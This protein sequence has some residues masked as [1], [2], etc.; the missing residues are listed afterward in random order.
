MSADWRI[1]Y[2]YINIRTS[3]ICIYV[4]IYD[5]IFGLA[6]G[7]SELITADLFDV[8]YYGSLF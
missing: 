4:H 7:W 2:V 6:Y 8:I 1:I 3:F 5:D